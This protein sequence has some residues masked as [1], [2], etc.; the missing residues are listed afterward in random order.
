[1]EANERK[2]NW[3]P[4]HMAK[5]LRQM[6]ADVKLCDGVI[7]VMDA[8]AVFACFNKRLDK[9]FGNKPIVYCINKRD[10]IS[11]A[12]AK[13]IES[14]FKANNLVYELIEG[15]SKR[16]GQN[17]RAKCDFVLKEKIER[18]AQKG[19]TRTL[20]FMVAGLPTTG[21]STIIN[22]M[23]GA[24]KAE[25]GN[26]AGV[27]RANKWI[28]LGSF[29]LLDTPGTMPP[30]IENQTYAR[31]L[32]FIGAMNDDILHAED[33]ALDLITELVKIAPNEFKEKYKLDTLELTP[34]EIFDCI[35]KKRGYLLRGGECDYE[36][37]AKA[38]IDDFRKGRIGKIALET[39]PILKAKS[40]KKDVE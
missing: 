29:D 26:K 34:L 10:L 7:L 16:D 20:R 15:L 31:H 28:R 17:L 18:N 36:R 25:T 5:A 35:C 38:I 1:M 32:A 37:A 24:K 2:L 4:G 14:Y 22:T 13:K 19:M 6:E 30:N 33:L 8:R 27:T 39:E 3:F 21:K 40:E 11:S 9:V 12:Q 23:S